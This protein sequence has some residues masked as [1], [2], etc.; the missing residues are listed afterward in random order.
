MDW[1]VVSFF[2]HRLIIKKISSIGRSQSVGPI[3]TNADGSPKR[4]IRSGSAVPNATST[5]SSKPY[6]KTPVSTPTIVERRPRPSK[7]NWLH[8]LDFEIISIFFWFQFNFTLKIYN[9]LFLVI[10]MLM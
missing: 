4:Q 8:V 5:S 10:L 1:Y 9:Q 6:K 2:P 3:T 7:F